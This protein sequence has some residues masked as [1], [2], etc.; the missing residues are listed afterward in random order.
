MAPNSSRFAYGF[1]IAALL[2]LSNQ[3]TDAS[4]ADA[5]HR[6]IRD[7]DAAQ[8]LAADNDQDLLIIFTGHGWCQPCEIFDRKVV[9]RPEFI[10]GVAADFICVEFDMN[11]GETEAEQER[12]KLFRSLQKKYLAEGVPTLLLVDAAG[13]PY[14]V[15]VGPDP[16]G[17]PQP[18][19]EKIRAAQAAQAE[20]ERRLA[21]ADGLKGT[22]RAV[23]LHDALLCLAPYLEP[24]DNGQDPLLEFYGAE[25][26]QLSQLL[27]E[28][29]P[30]R[31]FY[32]ERETLRAS[33]QR[34]QEIYAKINEFWETQDYDNAIEFVTT[35]LDEETNADLRSHLEMQRVSFLVSAKKHEETLQ[36]IAKL[37]EAEDVSDGNRASLVSSELHSL[38]ALNKTDEA[39]ATLN[40]HLESAAKQ[41]KLRQELLYE[42][43]S[44][45]DRRNQRP[46]AS[47]AWSAYREESAPNTF[48]RLTGSAFLARSL[49]K[50]NKHR[51]AIAL[52]EEIL[53]ALELAERGE[54]ELN[55]PWSYRTRGNTLLSVAE[56]Q[57]A[58]GNENE[59]R[60]RLDEAAENAE[61]LAASPTNGEREDA[62][63]MKKREQ[64]L[65][66]RLVELER[67]GSE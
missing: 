51:E 57:L 21:D 41:P 30:I 1:L 60:K 24:H 32:R 48:D 13:Q 47:A 52:F 56:S 7:F 40:A 17:G 9:Q 34:E 39:L 19:V 23:A 46:E 12:E 25:I 3:R 4:A 18:I 38:T 42:K 11:F 55:W 36:H 58:L 35:A 45:F 43:A 22:E 64:D 31:E 6:W 26:E 61:E 65:R 44:W 54:I 49:Q 59:A 62:E 67:R 14:C 15:I 10:D 29:S 20:R 28:N 66:A 8:K 33:K 63:S 27:P 5:P 50:E 2:I 37:L 53:T 16:S